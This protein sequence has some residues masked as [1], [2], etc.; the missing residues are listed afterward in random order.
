MT[1]KHTDKTQGSWEDHPISA[2]G[3]HPLDIHLS[4]VKA[5]AGGD[6]SQQLADLGVTDVEQLL[7][8]ANN[9]EG[10][11]NLAATLGVD[12]K[13][14][15]H[16]V[17]TGKKVLP[18]NLVAEL[19]HPLSAQ[20]SLGVLEPTEEMRAAA[21]AVSESFEAVAL[22]TSV[23]LISRFNPIRNQGQRG[24][25][26]AFALTAINEYF[27]RFG[28]GKPAIDLS[29]QHLYH[30]C[31]LVDG[32]PGGCGTWQRV[33]ASVLGSR[34]ECREVV[35]PYNPNLPCNNNGVMPSNARTDA[36]NYKVT[37]TAINPPTN[38]N[39]IK[40]YLS[41]RRPVG[42]S[43]PVF[44]SWY[45]SAETKRSGRITMPLSGDTQVGGHAIC[46]VGYQ[47]TPT[48]PGGGYFILRNSWSTTWAYQSPYLPGYGIIPYQY[49]TQ[50]NW[51]A[52]TLSG[53]VG[54]EEPM[55][56]PKEEVERTI[57]ITVRSNAHL[58]IE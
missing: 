55:P 23:N 11:D 43:I 6:S 48:S 17:E 25:C 14:I 50:Y 24:T 29:E 32:S 3:G 5:V 35:W 41:V 31:K 45:S 7:A 12:K 57:T 22:P 36:A 10:I 16:L 56:T 58:I 37:L 8:L 33:G 18:A 34:G 47:D 38:V 15:E 28:R 30:E 4:A 20:F 49:I 40:S 53:A 46:L 44:N 13:D 1:S 21:E 42:I 54:E 19:A 51:E 26:V 27:Q 52:Y 2:F 9:Q 39:S